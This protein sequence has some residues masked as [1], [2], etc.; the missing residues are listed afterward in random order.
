M[1]NY[2]VF[3]MSVRRKGCMMGCLDGHTY[4]MAGDTTSALLFVT[5]TAHNIIN[6]AEFEVASRSN[7]ERK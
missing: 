3:P 1:L 7:I 6:L 5:S 2:T 4:L